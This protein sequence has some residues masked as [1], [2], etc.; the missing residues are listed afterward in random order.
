MLQD[1][2]EQ[3]A[4]QRY[5]VGL[6][7]VYDNRV[8]HY[9]KFT[10]AVGNVGTY[11]LAVATDQILEN[12]DRRSVAPAKVIGDKTVT[13]DVTVGFAPNFLAFQGGVVAANEL[14][15]GHVEIWPVAGGNQFMYRKIMA[16]TAVSAGNITITVDKPFN[17]AVGIASQ[18]TIHPNIYRAV[19]SAVDAGLAG[20]QSAV[21]LPIIPVTINYFAWLQ[22]WG[23][24]FV[25]PTGAWPGSA[26]DYRDVYLHSDGCIADFVTEYAAGANI[27]P[28]RVGYVVNAGNYGAAEIMLQ[29]D[30]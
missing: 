15:G 11:R 22:T 28:Q 2:H 7:Y 21:G 10:N 1:F 16:N 24:C 12:N 3:S 5:P 9:A 4:I 29:L 27:S 14:I 13:I 26:H 19:K 30:P 25:A 18:V 6:R 8:F 23:L 20:F 17:F